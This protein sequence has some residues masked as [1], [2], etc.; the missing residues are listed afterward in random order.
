MKFIRSLTAI[1]L[2][3]ILLFTLVASTVLQSSAAGSQ[4]SSPTVTPSIILPTP[5][6]GQP[7][8]GWMDTPYKSSELPSDLLPQLQVSIEQA[9]QASIANFNKNNTSRGRFVGIELRSVTFDG[10][11][12]TIELA[13]VPRLNERQWSNLQRAVDRKVTKALYQASQLQGLAIQ[14]YFLVNGTPLDRIVPQGSTKPNSSALDTNGMKVAINPGHGYFTKS[15]GGWFLQ[16][17]YQYGIVEDFINLDLAIT[18]KQYMVASG[19][20]PYPVRRLNKNAGNHPSGYPWWQMDASE[21]VRSLGAPVEVWKPIPYSGTYDHDIAAR[22]EYANWI[23]ANSMVSIHNNGGGSSA[24]NSHGTETWYDTGNGYSTQSYNLANAIHSKVIQR[25]REGWD[26]SWCDRGIKGANGSLGENRR[27]RGPAALV[28]LGFMDVESDNSALQDP[29]FRAIAMAAINE[30][31]V[32]YYGGVPCPSITAWRGEYWNN[33]SL[34][35]YPVL[36]RNDNNLNFDWGSVGPGGSILSDR[37]S[38]RWTRT[39]N[40]NAGIY[41]FHV[42]GDDGIRLWIDGNLVIDKWLDQGPTEYTV[43]RTLSAGPH[44]F[45]IEYYENGGGA[46]ARFWYEFIGCP[47]QY[48]ARYYNNKTL[49]GSPT[50]TRCEGWPINSDWGSG[51]PGNGV[52]NDNF[53]VRWTGTASFNAGTYTFIAR[54]DDGIRVWL[55]GTLIIDKWF[56][57]GPTEYRV[58]RYV[59]AGNHNI[60][61]EYYENGG[62]A[63]AQFRWV[64]SPNLARNR[65]T[66][67]TSQESPDFASYKANDGSASTRWSSASTGLDEWWRVDLGS[68]QTF[69]RVVIRWEAAYAASHFVGWSNDGLNF[70]GYWFNLTAAGNYAYSLGTRTARYVAVLMRQRAPCCGNFSFWEFEI[71]RFRSADALQA[72]PFRDAIFLAPNGKLVTV[73]APRFHV[74]PGSTEVQPAISYP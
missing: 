6:G 33:R 19:A 23:G 47:N 52:G 18:L 29:T 31:V 61:V 27:F 14:Y 51:G 63:V 53:S 3:S 16:R 72:I 13:N 54:S 44:N 8:E 45:K 38:A 58:L 22:P 21:Y 56:D 42:L 1:S 67:A 64:S 28:E 20:S 2:A 62:G 12:I 36:C 68:E 11:V 34:S 59:A 50:F 71:Y 46:T 41:R 57:Q 60:K 49:S 74:P 65:P 69:D 40:L 30:G 24:C 32:Q 37:F 17:G 9:V 73:R 55:D 39:I 10:Q 70:S 25:I 26:P 7:A 43:D 66:W 4:T 48:F 5:E 35:G 15:T